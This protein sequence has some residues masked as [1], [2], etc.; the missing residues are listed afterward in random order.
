MK[1]KLDPG[2]KMPTRAHAKDAGLDIYAL[3]DGIVPPLGSAV[4]KT[5]VHIKL[6]PATFGDMRSKSGL[7]FNHGI[8]SDGTIDEGYTGEIMVK[9]FNHSRTLYHVRAGDRISQLVIVPIVRES[10]ELVSQLE[11]TSD[12]G[13]AGFGS[14]G[15]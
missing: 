14:T 3:H 8:T 12:R 2:A 7:M 10:M 5:G 6:P 4:F 15:R 13:A 9:L 11:D 1:I